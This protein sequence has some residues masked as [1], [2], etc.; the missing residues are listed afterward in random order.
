[1]PA[2]AVNQPFPLFS[3]QNGTLLDNAYLYFGVE[4]LEPVSNPITVYIDENLTVPISQPIRTSG[5]YPVSGGAPQKLYVGQNYSI[6][7]L[8]KN[9]AFVFASQSNTVFVQSE[10]VQFS[11]SIPGSVTRTIKNKANDFLSVEDFGAVGNG[12]TND[13]AAFNAMIAATGGYIRI[14]DK[15]YNVQTLNYT[16]YDKVVIQGMLRPEPNANLTKLQNGSII[17]GQ[18]YVEANNVVFENFGVDSGSARS[19]SSRGGL[20]ANAKQSQNG[21]K[22]VVRNVSALNES[23][24]GTWHGITVQGYDYNEIKDIYVAKQQFGIVMKGRNCIISNVIAVEC[25]T[26]SVYP[27]SDIPAYAGNVANAT[28]LNVEVDNVISMPKSTNVDCAGVYCHASS[29][30]I[31]KIC[32]NNVYQTYG[33]AAV[34]LQ[35]GGTISDPAISAVDVSNVIAESAQYAVVYGGYTYDTQINNVTAINPATGKSVA[36]TT[37]AFSWAITNI[38]TLISDSAITS[39]TCLELY[40]IGLFDNITVRNPY[41]NMKVAV[42]S[43]QLGQ[44]CTGKV[45]YGVFIENEGNL[46]GINGTTLDSSDPAIIKIMPRSVIRLSGKF[47]TTSTTNKAICNLPILTGKQMVFACAGIDSSNAYVSI[48]VRLNNFQLTIE[49]SLPSGFKAIDVSNISIPLI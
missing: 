22:A 24:S 49:P 18:V 32:V 34:R 19:V 40:G 10:D 26:A 46:T 28:V 41:R 48:V 39:D 45:G 8:D 36:T 27:K 20:W 30:A 43:A 42:Q 29:A 23:D 2:I 14:L 11:P 5:G 16:T 38:H 12:V 1:M 7:I 6:K 17:I 44:I 33:M 31:S 21:V 25:R 35:G 15:E 3:D 47:N 13:S 37:N 9:G 4:N